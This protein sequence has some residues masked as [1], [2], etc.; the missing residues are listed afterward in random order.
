MIPYKYLQATDQ[1]ADHATL[2]EFA[3]WQMGEECVIMET[4]IVF[5]CQWE[6]LPLIVNSYCGG[7]LSNVG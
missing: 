5:E 1:N 2:V 3:E 4:G 7:L 6:D